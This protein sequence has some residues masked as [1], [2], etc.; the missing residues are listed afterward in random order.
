MK[1]YAIE[2]ADGGVVILQVF[3]DADPATELRKW[4]QNGQALL[5][6]PFNIR[7]IGPVDLPID[8]VF[9]DA[10]KDSGSKISVDMPKARVIH[11]SRIREARNKKL[12]LLDK[13]WMKEMGQEGPPAADIIETRREALRNIPATFDLDR[14][15]TPEDLETAWP[16]DLSD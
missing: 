6:Q 1:L 11:M 10:W 9:R 3:K 8:R 14:Y 2:R 4:H 5:K 12:D 15:Q 7:G 13:D 16:P